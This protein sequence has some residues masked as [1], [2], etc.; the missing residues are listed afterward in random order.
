[1]PS[2]RPRAIA[3]RCRPGMG[4][5]ISPAFARGRRTWSWR[6][7]PRQARGGRFRGRGLG[8]RA[9]C[10]P[11]DITD[12]DQ[13]HALAAAGGRQ[14]WPHRRA[15]EQRLHPAAPRDHR[16]QRHEDVAQGLRG[17][18]VR[19]DPDDQGGHPRHEGAGQ[20]SIVFINSM[21]ARRIQPEFGICGCKSAL[22]TAVQSLARELGG[23]GIRA[24]PCCPATSGATW[25]SGTSASLPS[26]RASPLRRSTTRWPARPACTTCRPPRRRRLGGLLRRISAGSSRASPLDVNAGHWLPERRLPTVQKLYSWSVPRSSR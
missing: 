2:K 15:G 20:G 8:R 16:G 21:S 13:C 18:R 14:V 22:L 12:E 5:H 6:P 26:R 3:P 9:L 19:H 23:Y 7:A 1:M 17:Q 4:R 25:W 24:N 11:T 10:V